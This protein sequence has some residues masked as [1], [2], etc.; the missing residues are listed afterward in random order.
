MTSPVMK[1]PG[2]KRQRGWGRRFLRGWQRGREDDGGAIFW[3][4]FGLKNGIGHVGGDPAGG[5]G[6]HEDIVPG[7]FAGEALGE[8]DDAAFGG[9]VVGMQDSPRCPRWS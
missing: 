6:V 9:A 1:W 4:A 2:P 3:P 8:A 7:E 5:D